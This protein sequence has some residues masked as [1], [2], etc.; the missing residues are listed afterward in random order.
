MIVTNESKLFYVFTR[1]W[2]RISN[3]AVVRFLCWCQSA[4]H[5]I[6]NA[7]LIRHWVYDDC[8]WWVPNQSNTKTKPLLHGINF[9]KHETYLH[10]RSFFKKKG[11]DVG[12][13]HTL[14]WKGASSMHWQYDNVWGLGIRSNGIEMNIAEH[15]SFRIKLLSAFY[16]EY[17]RHVWFKKPSA[18][19]LTNLICRIWSLSNQLNH[20]Y[21]DDGSICIMNS[22]A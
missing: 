18:L 11:N 13:W 10:F 15:Y 5:R 17:T 22:A 16:Q 8:S 21:G 3:P 19:N 7:N 12:D 1:I 14:R 20:S 4:E 6:L 2:G 9:R